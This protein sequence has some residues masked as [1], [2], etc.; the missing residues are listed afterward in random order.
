MI[1]LEQVKKRVEALE[2]NHHYAGHSAFNEVISKGMCLLC[3]LLIL[4][5]E[6]I[7]EVERLQV[8]H[9]DDEPSWRHRAEKL[10]REKAELQKEVESLEQVVKER[11]GCAYMGPSKDCPTHGES[12][13]LEQL[14]DNL[15]KSRH[16][17]DVTNEQFAELQREK[18]E[19]EKKA[20]KIEKVIDQFEDMCGRRGI[21]PEFAVA[22]IRGQKGS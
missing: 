16:A 21:R 20:E 19:L 10:E 22:A 4:A 6:L 1:D 12:T 2:K 7:E 18:A 13:E 11:E 3:A 5:H 15:A 14:K 9:C 17:H 8:Y